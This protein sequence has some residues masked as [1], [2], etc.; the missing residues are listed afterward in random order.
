MTKQEKQAYVASLTEQ[1]T[2][3]KAAVLTEYHGTTVAQMEQL[4]R[5]LYAKGIQYK[6]AKNS[7]V[8]RTLDDLGIVVTDLAI[9][10]R[11]VAIAASNTD[12][13]EL[14]KALASAHKEIETIIPVAGIVNGSFVGA[15]VIQRLATLPSREELYAKMVGS[16]AGLPTRMV[17]TIANPMQGLVTALHQIQAKKEA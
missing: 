6:V 14:A 5:Q 3:S 8:K 16:L 13:V 9:L 2:T 4:R 12:E 11:P 10:D 7:L 1:L 15:S 17:R